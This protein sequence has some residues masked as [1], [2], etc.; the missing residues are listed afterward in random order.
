MSR[1]LVGA[2]CASL[3]LPA[4]AQSPRIQ[5]A[6]TPE[7]RIA[8]T[9]DAGELR[10]ATAAWATRLASG[11]IAVADLA[12]SNVRV[13]GTDGSLKRTL[14]RRG[15]GPG[16]YRLPVW[17]GHCGANVIVWDASARA[18]TYTAAASS[19]ETPGTRTIGEGAQSLS[20]ACGSDGSLALLQ[21]L[22]PRRD[23][24]PILTGESPFGG[25]YQ[26][27][28]MSAG[29]V[30][31]DATAGA[32]TLRES[33]AQGQ[34]AMGRISPQGGM[35]ALPRPLS[36]STTFAFAGEHLVIADGASG[37]VAGLSADGRE[38]F[39]FSAASAAPRRPGADDYRRA[40]GAS[41]ELVPAAL[42]DDALKLV[43]AIP[44][45]ESLPH[46]WRILSDPDGHLWLVTSPQ[47]AAETHFRVYTRSGQLIAEPRVAGAFE[48]FEV[49]AAHLL[50]KRENTDGED[51]IVLLRVTRSR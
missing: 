30:V 13:L 7:L 51:E 3:A 11:E 21:G 46:F 10:F 43:Q 27:V 37:E 50:G 47:G 35:G 25:Q 44:L 4:G 26:V 45:P 8:A 12:E 41:I 22:A 14:G 33:I 29:L 24:P 9:T 32:R 31:V 6:A 39:R 28:Q 15:S 5:V 34:W 16:E 2:V 1:I 36:A 42:R 18:T 40:S 17:I 38:A 19:T 49:G 23:I 48:P 20:A